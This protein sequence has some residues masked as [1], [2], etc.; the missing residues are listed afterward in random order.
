MLELGSKSQAETEKKLQ[1]VLSSKKEKVRVNEIITKKEHRSLDGRV[2][3]K[4]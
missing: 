2:I 4:V 3:K 1:I